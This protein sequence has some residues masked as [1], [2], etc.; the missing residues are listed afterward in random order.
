MFPQPAGFPMALLLTEEDVRVLLDI[1][2]AIKAVEES[3]R[4]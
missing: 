4:R 3:F 2:E 1:P